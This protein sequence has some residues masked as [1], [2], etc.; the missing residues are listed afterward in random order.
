ML[1]GKFLP[2]PSVYYAA[3]KKKK[4]VEEDCAEVLQSH[5]ESPWF[6]HW[7]VRGAGEYL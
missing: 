2:P 1:V 6:F 4:E 7:C 3:G 5:T